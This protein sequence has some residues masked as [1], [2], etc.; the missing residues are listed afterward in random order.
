MVTSMDRPQTPLVL[1]GNP[2]TAE[3]RQDIAE[4]RAPRLEHLELAAALQAEVISAADGDAKF[5]GLVGSLTRR[6]KLLSA[7]LAAYARRSDFSSIYVTGEDIGLRIAP[8]LRLNG[9]RGRLVVVVHA[10]TSA[11]RKAYFRALGPDSFHALICVC[12]AQRRILVD[13]LGFPPDKVKFCPNWVDTDFFAPESGRTAAQGDY[14]FSCGRENRDYATLFAAAER[15]PYAFK[16]AASGFRHDGGGLGAAPANLAL[17]DQRISFEELR[18]T[19]A[20]CRLVVAPLHAVP[21]AAGVT[22]VVEAMAMG[23]AVIATASPGIVDYVEDGVSGRVTPPGDPEALAQAIAELW[24]DP[25]R[26]EAI[27]RRNRAWVQANASVH[28]YVQKIAKLMSPQSAA[29]SV[30]ANAAAASSVV[31]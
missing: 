8:F 3:M 22:G 17:F 5:K 11:L 19:Y 12:E 4:G 15:L 18:K 14:V 2:P 24:N 26:C 27:G 21:Y 31:C 30:P 28:G 16:V 25:D 9:W 6:D 1:L 29:I 10:C 20:D 13:E 7:S 23:K